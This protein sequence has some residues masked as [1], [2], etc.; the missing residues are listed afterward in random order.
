M[1]F[2]CRAHRAPGSEGDLRSMPET[3]WRALL[4]GQLQGL[5]RPQRAQDRAPEDGTAL[6]ATVAHQR[7]NACA[8]KAP[9]PTGEG[10]A[11]EDVGKGAGAT[12]AKPASGPANASA[13]PEALRAR[14]R[15]HREPA[16][17]GR[18]EQPATP[19]GARGSPREATQAWE[20]RGQCQEARRE[21]RPVAA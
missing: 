14:T 11:R 18:D 13:G 9:K 17:R 1:P 3:I 8:C 6:Q 12:R 10:A 19:S 15:D 5:V 20:H 7:R 16:L 21:A 2:S 4:P